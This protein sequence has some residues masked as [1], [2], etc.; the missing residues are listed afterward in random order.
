MS[1]RSAR[2]TAS[3][4]SDASGDDLEVGR[5][6]EHHAQA[7]P[8]DRVVVGEQDADRQR[9]AHVDRQPQLHLG[10]AGG[11]MSREVAPPISSARSRM[12]RTPL[13]ARAAPRRC[14][15][16]VAHAQH[17]APSRSA[18]SARRCV[19]RGVARDV[20]QALLRHAVDDELVLGG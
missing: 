3:M 6:L 5:G 19:A 8:H 1:S 7:A 15:A 14:R 16:V 20:G 9:V 11:R 17:D 12:P 2:S 18:G 10:A 4:P 13:R